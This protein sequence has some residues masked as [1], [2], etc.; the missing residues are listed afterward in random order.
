MKTPLLI[1]TRNEGKVREFADMLSAVGDFDV[2]SLSDVD[3]TGFEP[4]ETG[5]TFRVN[6]C[7]K[8]EAYAKRLN[9]L[10]L[11]DDS[12]LSVDALG[13]APGVFSA[14]FAKMA[15]AGE[16]DAAN[17]AHLLRRLRKIPDDQRRA[18]F[19]CVLALAGP[20][21]GTLFTA[22]GRFDGR[23]LHEPRGDNGFGYDPLFYVDDAGQ[24]SAEM[25]SEEKHARSH[26]GQAT[27]R[28]QSLIAKFGLGKSNRAI[29]ADT[30]TR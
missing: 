19:A 18:H 7:F 9:M 13:G 3:A 24:T 14:R 26:R 29:N 16:G 25:T 15:G 30:W 21:R 8:A 12:G 6:A 20:E 5:R 17:N 2:H 4:A 10:A 11:A 28:L 1:A 22:A 23:I 27:R